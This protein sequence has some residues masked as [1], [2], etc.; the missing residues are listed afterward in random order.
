MTALASSQK[1]RQ[2]PPASNWGNR[3]AGCYYR[4]DRRLNVHLFDE[5]IGLHRAFVH[6]QAGFAS[7]RSANTI[8][9]SPFRLHSAVSGISAGLTSAPASQPHRYLAGQTIL[10]RIGTYFRYIVHGTICIWMRQA[11]QRH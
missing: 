6:Q 1:G 10:Q 3:S 11:K 7:A 4:D 5:R 9:S 2:P 8:I